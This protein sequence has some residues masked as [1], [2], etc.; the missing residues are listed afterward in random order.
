[1]SGYLNELAENNAKI[2]DPISLK[3][4]LP[5]CDHFNILRFTNSV[6]LKGN[7]LR[8]HRYISILPKVILSM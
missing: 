4:S 8:K 7:R 5:Y 6:D 2:G 3:V 1:M